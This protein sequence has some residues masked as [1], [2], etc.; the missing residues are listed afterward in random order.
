MDTGVPTADEPQPVPENEPDRVDDRRDDR[1]EAPP[2]KKKRLDRD[3]DFGPGF[4]SRVLIEW[5]PTVLFAFGVF[6]VIVFTAL[7]I[8]GRAASER[9]T[10]YKDR[11]KNDLEREKFELKPRK[12]RSEWTKAE[13]AKVDEETPKLQAK[14]DRLIEQA[15]ID[16]ESTRV[17]NIRDVWM[18][19][20]GLMLGFVFVSFGCIGYLRMEQRTEY[21]LVLKIVAGAIL[22]LMMLAMFA[23]FTGC[24]GLR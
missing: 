11:L 10:A 16:A 23:R 18:E 4:D 24:T 3:R 22:T 1:D 5:I 8:I 20:Y 12:P 9:A 14:Y 6:L 19:Q 15:G 2:K 13:E 21:G 17:G 7:P